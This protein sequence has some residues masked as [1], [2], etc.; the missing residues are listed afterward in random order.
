M[1]KLDNQNGKWNP[2]IKQDLTAR[3][4]RGRIELADH[5][6]WIRHGTPRK[7]DRSQPHL[8]RAES[9]LGMGCGEGYGIGGGGRYRP[10]QLS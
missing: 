10:R 9:P 2:E 4:V 3:L 5:G 6:M 8:N 7:I 1:I